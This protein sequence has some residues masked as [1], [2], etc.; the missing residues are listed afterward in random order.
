MVNSK[1]SEPVSTKKKTINVKGVHI[2]NGEIVD[3]DGSI[4][5][6]LQDELGDTEF[7][8]KITVPVTEESGE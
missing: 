3:D 5:G 1:I 2:E 4:I 6:R 7:S 8:F